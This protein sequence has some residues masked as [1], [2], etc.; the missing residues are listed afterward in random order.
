MA[1]PYIIVIK[2]EWGNYTSSDSVDDRLYMTAEE[3]LNRLDE[4]QPRYREPLGIAG[5]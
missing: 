1:P 3:V 4:L 5:C 2:N